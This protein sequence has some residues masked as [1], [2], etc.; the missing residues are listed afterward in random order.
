MELL[1]NRDKVLFIRDNRGKLCLGLEDKVNYLNQNLSTHL[2][3]KT[4]DVQKV[5]IKLY[6]PLTILADRIS[7]T[8][9]YWKIDKYQIATKLPLLLEDLTP[10]V[11]EARLQRI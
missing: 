11:E 1:I 9:N 2:Q 4:L 7:Q 8:S 10:R 5:Q 3:K 6:M